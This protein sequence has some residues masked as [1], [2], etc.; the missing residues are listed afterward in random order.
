LFLAGLRAAGIGIAAGLVKSIFLIGFAA[1]VSMP[2]IFLGTMCVRFVQARVPRVWP[3]TFALLV[4]A[5]VVFSVVGL[6]DFA[7]TWVD[8]QGHAWQ[9]ATLAPGFV[10]TIGAAILIECGVILLSIG[11]W[12][13]TPKQGAAG[14][15]LNGALVD[16]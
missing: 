7:H 4:I 2:V 3:P 14:V 16:A 11:A 5:A 15:L 12:Y 1:L 10:I 13:P 9:R 6:N 8:P